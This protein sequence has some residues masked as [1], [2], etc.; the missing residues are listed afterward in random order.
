M[1]H[2]AIFAENAQNY[3]TYMK[4]AT[5]LFLDSFITI[6]F[7]LWILAVDVLGRELMVSKFLHVICPLVIS[8]WWI[9]SRYPL[10]QM[11]V[12]L[13]S[14]ASKGDVG[15]IATAASVLYKADD[16]DWA[17]LK[18]R[19]DKMM[20]KT[21]IKSILVY[22]VVFL[23][24]LLF[25]TIKLIPTAITC[26]NNWNNGEKVPVECGGWNEALGSFGLGGG[27]KSGLKG[28]DQEYQTDSLW[29]Y[30]LTLAMAVLQIFIDV[31]VIVIIGM[32]MTN[33]LEFLHEKE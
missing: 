11:N 13:E 27:L 15:A 28:S 20:W 31:Y 33:R 3:L 19:H 2:R 8:H 29:L 6:F 9:L 25:L 30:W 32:S 26:V 16:A 12:M 1:Q 7:V 23:V 17:E 14:Y 4:L 24:D 10:H 5:A 18:V 21:L 22:V